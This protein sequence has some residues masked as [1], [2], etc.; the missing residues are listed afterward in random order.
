MICWVACNM[1]QYRRKHHHFANQQWK[2]GKAHL[3]QAA[4]TM[5]SDNLIFSTKLRHQGSHGLAEH[6]GVK[7][8]TLLSVNDIA[9]LHRQVSCP[10]IEG[11][12]VYFP[13]GGLKKIGAWTG[14]AKSTSRVPKVHIH[15]FSYTF[16]HQRYNTPIFWAS[17]RSNIHIYCRA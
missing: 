12:W 16:H 7:W 6:C 11:A 2:H 13:P 14:S 9:S 17:E 8:V 3:A 15:T 5:I 1:C 4:T 10:F